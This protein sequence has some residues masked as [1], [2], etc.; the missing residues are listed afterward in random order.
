MTMPARFLLT[1]L[2][3]DRALERPRPSFCPYSPDCR[4]LVFL[5]AGKTAGSSPAERASKTSI[6]RGLSFT[7]SPAIGGTLRLSDESVTFAHHQGLLTA[8]RGFCE[9]H[10]ITSFAFSLGGNT[11]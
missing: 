8:S 7:F 6:C 4:E 9:S 1:Q 2:E 11:G 3:T 10:S 5:E